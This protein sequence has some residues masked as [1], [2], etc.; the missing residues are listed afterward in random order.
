MET[1][2]KNPPLRRPLKKFNT[3]ILIWPN[4]ICR[5]WSC[6]DVDRSCAKWRIAHKTYLTS[7]KT[8]EKRPGLNDT[9]AVAPFSTVKIP[10]ER[11]PARRGLCRRWSWRRSWP[12]LRASCRAGAGWTTSLLAAGRPRESHRGQRWRWSAPDLASIGQSCPW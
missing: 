11:P 6:F 3:R 1:I 5:F 4:H 9:V 10:A 8:E 2:F 7:S 12:C